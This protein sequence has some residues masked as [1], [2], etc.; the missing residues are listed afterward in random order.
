MSDIIRPSNRSSMSI[1]NSHMQ[2]ISNFNRLSDRLPY[3]GMVDKFG[4][5]RLRLAIIDNHEIIREQYSRIDPLNTKKIIN[6]NTGEL[7]LRWID[8]PGGI[9]RPTGTNNDLVGTWKYHKDKDK[10]NPEDREFDEWEITSRREMVSLTHPFIWANDKN[11]CGF[12]YIPPIGSVVIVGF[13]KHG[14]PVI[15]GYVPTHYK[16]F[17]PVLKPGEMV[18][19]GYG[20][21]YTHWRWTDKIDFKAWS[22]KDEIDIDYTDDYTEEER[23]NPT[24]CTLWIRLNANK[25]FI[26]LSAMEND[27]EP[28]KAHGPHQTVFTLTPKTLSVKSEELED[29]DHELKKYTEYI[30][31]EEGFTK[32]AYANKETSKY[33][34]NAQS[35]LTDI[36][37]EEEDYETHTF[38]DCISIKN[39]VL[40][41]KDNKFTN[42]LQNDETI[43]KEVISDNFTTTA[44]YRDE[45]ITLNT[46]NFI[47]NAEELVQITTKNTFVDSE[48]L[49]DITTKETTVNSS[50][51]IDIT[52]KVTNLTSSDLVSVTTN[53]AIVNAS[54]SATLNTQAFLVN[55]NSTTING[56]VNLD[57]GGAPVARLGDSVVVTT[58]FGPAQG[59]I[60]SGSGTVSSGG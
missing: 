6:M 48:E 46:K 7:T 12:N 59:V 25:R 33:Y 19:K 54:I 44:K 2:N 28:K 4:E 52:T 18:M 24:D 10:P 31:D 13:K 40:N 8:L 42:L 23:V 14:F 16:I 57:G 30:Q 1:Q 32:Y 56:S 60:T 51:L 27:T 17:Y 49:I 43:E 15:L 37:N 45:S 26:Q 21:N 3:D 20:N 39:N 9:I 11:Y 5:V 29:D 50:D 55:A 53:E 22:I 36:I 47:L 38:Q 34:Q 58:A 35:I 41:N